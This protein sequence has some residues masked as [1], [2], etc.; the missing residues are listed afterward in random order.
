MPLSTW[1]RPHSPLLLLG[2]V[3]KLALAVE[4]AV[5]RVGDVAGALD[6]VRLDELVPRADLR[7]DG[8]RGLLLEGRQAR[9]HGRHPDR[10]VPE[11]L[12]RDRQDERAVD[13]AR[14]ADER[15]PHFPQK[16][17]AIARAVARGG[18]EA[19]AA[20]GLSHSTG[21]GALPELLTCSVLEV[22]HVRCPRR[23]SPPRLAAGVE[24]PPAPTATTAGAPARPGLAGARRGPAR[25]RVFP[26][27]SSSWRRR[28]P[29]AGRRAWRSPRCEPA[30]RATRARGARG[31]DPEGSPACARGG[32]G[33]RRSRADAR[34]THP[35]APAGQVGVKPSATGALRGRRVDVDAQGRRVACVRGGGDSRRDAPEAGRPRCS[36]ASSPWRPSRA[37]STVL[38][39]TD[40]RARAR[41]RGRC[42]CGSSCRGPTRARSPY[43]SRR[44]AAVASVP[45]RTLPFLPVQRLA[46]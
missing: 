34:R 22:R 11:D 25:R 13:A 12:V 7:R 5:G 14:V 31:F 26:R 37:G 40:R 32:G 19:G 18:G 45:R 29:S 20:L 1:A 17:R 41:R 9:R 16:L 39:L 2:D 46:G 3:V 43:A 10:P 24:G 35:A 38:L 6:L 36:C 4:A 15:T 33:G 28:A 42:R 21:C 44:T 30:R 23:R 8:D 27:A